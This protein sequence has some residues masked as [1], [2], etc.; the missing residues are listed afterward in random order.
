MVSAQPDD[1]VISTAITAALA[2]ASAADAF[3]ND[4]EEEDLDSPPDPF[5]YHDTKKAICSFRTALQ[6]VANSLSCKHQD[7]PLIIAIDELDRCRPSY[8]VELLEVVK[9]F[10]AVT[11]IVFVL[12]I[13]KSQL[14]HAIQAIYGSNFDS[15]GYL[16]RFIDL[17]FRLPDPD[18][19]EFINQLMINTG[20]KTFMGN[21]PHSSW[22]SPRNAENL[23]KTFLSLPTLSVR[24][25]QQTLHRLGLVLTSMDSTETIAYGAIAMLTILKT[26]DP[27]IYQR[28]VKA[29]IT[30]KETLEHL[31][32]MPGV[33][34][35]MS[36]RNETLFEALLIMGYGEFA[37][38]N[39]KPITTEPSLFHDYSAI[40]EKLTYFPMDNAT[41]ISSLSPPLSDR[42]KQIL[43]HMKS[44]GSMFT[45]IQKG[46]PAGF[47]LTAQRLELFSDDLTEY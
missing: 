30:D 35:I 19:H 18:R 21:H 16:R 33:Q 2:A 34:S 32:G 11:N 37:L 42:E 40:I 36:T 12:A 5:T 10:F 7:N 43:R 45:E 41:E 39:N 6:D 28:F 9:H 44:H 29:D 23:L 13:D 25:I 17:D 15:V 24:Q 26:I 31:F 1:Q 8:A 4:T 20:I 3:S 27:D 14:S 38:M 47:N 46:A 22:G